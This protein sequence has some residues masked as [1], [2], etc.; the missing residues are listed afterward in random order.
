M[1]YL[2][3]SLFSP[4]NRRRTNRGRF[5]LFKIIGVCAFVTAAVGTA[6]GEM[7]AYLHSAIAGFV[8]EVPAK[9]SYSISTIQDGRQTTER[10]DPSKPPTEQWQLLQMSG[11]NPTPDET[12]KYFRYKASQ[13]P[14][15]IKATFHKDDIEPGSLKLVR[16]NAEHAVFTCK[17]REV[18]T[19]GDK[20]LGHLG[21][22][23]TVNKRLGFV[24]RYRMTLD[25][26]YSP[27]FSVKMNELIV[28]MDFTPPDETHPSLP[29]RSSSHF[30]GRIFLIPTQENIT[31]RYFDF[32]LV[33]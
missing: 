4:T 30:A 28:T 2:S 29:S 19:E 24:E 10:F 27:V 33:P 26:A 18:S 17:F 11:H 16:E 25:A 20:M 31:Y 15:A 22:L 1:G 6:L 8:P 3:D 23:L 12:S 14:G 21:L 5:L 32:A 9:W 7:P 13:I